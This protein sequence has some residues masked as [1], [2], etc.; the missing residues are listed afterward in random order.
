[1]P[2]RPEALELLRSD[3]PVQRAIGVFTY[4][5]THN[6]GADGG[7]APVPIDEI[8]P[9]LIPNLVQ[10]ARSDTDLFVR[11]AA[12]CQLREVLL[13]DSSKHIL[14]QSQLDLV[15][16]ALADTVGSP[17][18]S[19]VVP[20][21]FMQQGSGAPVRI[22]AA[23]VD[24]D[25]YVRHT[26]LE[27]GEPALRVV[28]EECSDSIM[29]ADFIDLFSQIARRS[30]PETLASFVAHPQEAIRQIASEAISGHIETHL[31]GVSQR[32]GVTI[33]DTNMPVVIARI[34]KLDLLK[35]G[36]KVPLSTLMD[37]DPTTLA[38]TNEEERKPI[39]VLQDF[40]LQVQERL[41]RIKSALAVSG[42][43]VPQR[44]LL[45]RV[46]EALE[47]LEAV[48]CRLADHARL[49]LP[50]REIVYRGLRPVARRRPTG[51]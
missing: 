7:A 50:P 29:G 49:Q 20:P 19:V 23:T 8:D 18:R 35:V 44:K 16:D 51:F 45:E 37:I 46:C 31:P 40:I 15:L 36:G 25:Q 22:E 5:L 6:D 14:A 30:C 39:R 9:A 11:Y 48:H 2:A 43:S 4:W 28:A 32:G 10:I 17:H 12:L 24:L 1:M 27:V 26:L 38:A 42:E 21:V 34:L 41:G 13:L 3:D 47:R 33:T